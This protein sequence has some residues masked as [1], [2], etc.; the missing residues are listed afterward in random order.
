MKYYY[1]QPISSN[2]TYG[3][4]KE[5]IKKFQPYYATRPCWE[6][7]HFYDIYGN[8]C[9]L[10]STG[11]VLINPEEIHDTNKVDWQIVVIN[12]EALEQINKFTK[13]SNLETIVV[14]E[15]KFDYDPN[16]FKITDDIIKTLQSFEHEEDENNFYMYYDESGMLVFY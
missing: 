1:K 13:I 7:V 5:L 11:E 3:Q 8:Y 14:N 9:I 2:L 6:G 4:A 12:E 15:V 16:N 10:L